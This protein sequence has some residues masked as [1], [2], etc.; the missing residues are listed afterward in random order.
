MI[1]YDYF[2]SSAAFRCRIGLNLKGLTPE[3]RF[4]HL[5]RRE[6]RSPDYLAVNP[7]GL[8]PALQL[9]DGTVLIQSLAIIEYLDAMPPTP[10]LLPAEPVERARVSAISL[11]IACEIHP[12]QSL[13]VL[14]YLTDTFGVD[15]ETRTRKWC[16]YC[17]E[18]GLRG[19]EGSLAGHRHTGRYCHGDRPTLA[20]CCLVPQILNAR[21]FGCDLE[22]Y[23][24]VMRIVAECASLP[25][26]A[27]AAPAVQPDAEA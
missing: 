11:A 22:P 5:R 24:E 26:F 4:V 18:E 13:R 3:R 16:R 2:R 23:P 8:V 15:E 7:Q 27:D 19:V 17:I 14:N 6:H 21:R 12:I 9:V 1:F 25:A 10:P 20:D